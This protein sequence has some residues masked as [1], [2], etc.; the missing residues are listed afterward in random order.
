MEPRI[1]KRKIENGK[2]KVEND[3]ID[4]WNMVGMWIFIWKN[5]S[6]KKCDLIRRFLDFLNS[7]EVRHESN[8][9]GVVF[10]WNIKNKN[11]N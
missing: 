11:I 9:Y 1:Y 10:Y 8:A 2:L 4:I 6:G 3:K 7:N 5:D